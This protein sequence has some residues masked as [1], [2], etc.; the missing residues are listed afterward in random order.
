ML[1]TY[2][3]P[4]ND[5]AAADPNLNPQQGW[6]IAEWFSRSVAHC[7]EPIFQVSQN[8]V[9]IASRSKA[10]SAGCCTETH[11][12]GTVCTQAE[13]GPMPE[14]VH[15]PACCADA[16]VDCPAVTSPTEH[17]LLSYVDDARMV[18]Q[19]LCVRRVSGDSKPRADAAIVILHEGARLHAGGLRI[20]PV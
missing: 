15:P 8:I 13:M 1:G 18:T 7:W 16:D 20:M 4:Q 5:S 14:G 19:I 12:M 6:S 11:T 2:T 9:H 17:A 10:F 3:P